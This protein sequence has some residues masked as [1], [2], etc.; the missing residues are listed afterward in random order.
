MDPVPK[1][2]SLRLRQYTVKINFQFDDNFFIFQKPI[3]YI[4]LKMNFQFDK[5][6]YSTLFKSTISFEKNIIIFVEL[7]IYFQK[8]IWFRFPEYEEIVVKLKINFLKS[9]L[10]GSLGPLSSLIFSLVSQWRKS[11]QIVYR[12]N[13]MGWVTT[14]AFM[15][16]LKTLFGSRRLQFIVYQG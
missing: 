15:K 2:S 11:H 13:K 10:S 5:N 6:Y 4:F 14:D 3:S 7:K 9:I 16:R 8:N 1:N 12:N